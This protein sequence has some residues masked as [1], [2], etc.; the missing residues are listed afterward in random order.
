MVKNGQF[1]SVGDDI[2]LLAFLDTSEVL[3]SKNNGII[4]WYKL[5]GQQLM[6]GEYYASIEFVLP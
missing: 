4:T 2:C 3:Q 6:H 1:V 5:P